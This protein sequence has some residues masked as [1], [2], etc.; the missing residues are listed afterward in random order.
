MVLHSVG[1]NDV[2][3]FTVKKVDFKNTKCNCKPRFKRMYLMQIT[4]FYTIKLS[5]GGGST[6]KNPKKPK[7]KMGISTIFG[8]FGFFWFFWFFLGF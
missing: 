1:L 7:P 6:P 2:K 8:F 5:F 4:L 3:L